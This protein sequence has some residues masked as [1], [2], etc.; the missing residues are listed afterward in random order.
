MQWGLG[1][2]LPDISVKITKKMFLVKRQVINFVTI[3]KDNY[4][5]VFP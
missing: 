3:P 4:G 5:P 2:V 1:F